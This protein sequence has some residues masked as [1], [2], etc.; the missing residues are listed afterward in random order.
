MAAISQVLFSDAIFVNQKF[1]ILIK[2]S[3]N[4]VRKG[5]IDNNS[6]GLVNSLVLNRCQAII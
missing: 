6:T 4:F 1:C 3:L 2:I 5:P